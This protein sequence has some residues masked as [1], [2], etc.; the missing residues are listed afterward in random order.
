M[1]KRRHSVDLMGKWMRAFYS[2]AK[3][4]PSDANVRKHAITLTQKFLCT[5][6]GANLA[7][8]HQTLIVRAKRDHFFFG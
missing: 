6:F 5:G 7:P 2:T 4:T 1:R 3:I 8:K